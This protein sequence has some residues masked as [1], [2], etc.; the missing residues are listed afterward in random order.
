MPRLPGIV[1][2]AN[3]PSSYIKVQV[4][5]K[6]AFALVDTGAD[7]SLIN[8]S[9]AVAL[10]HPI[11]PLPSTSKAAGITGTSPDLVGTTRVTIKIAGKAYTC[12]ICVLKNSPHAVLLGEDFLSR[13]DFFGFEYQKGKF[14]IDNVSLALYTKDD[15]ETE[16]ATVSAS[17]T[18]KL[19]PRSE[20]ILI[21]NVNT[22]PIKPVSALF[23]PNQ[24]LLTKDCIAANAVVT[25]DPV[26]P[27]RF[28]NP[29]SDEVTIFKG[30]NV[31]TLDTS[32]TFPNPS[33]VQIN[34]ESVNSVRGSDN[35][36][37]IVSS[38]LC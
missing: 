20:T 5:D 32:V 28:C 3:R 12:K 30:E 10:A 6:L 26:I 29:T 31:G 33:G 4:K 13:F 27:V 15:I 9:L 24:L 25:T 16:V 1:A 21:C 22:K 7:I 2:A 8:H 17:A 18:S 37:A 38:V 23:S 19:A 14:W 34:L 35:F 36:R 11:E